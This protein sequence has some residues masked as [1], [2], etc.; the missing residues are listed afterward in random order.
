[1]DERGTAGWLDGLGASQYVDRFPR[2][3]IR[4]DVL[5]DLSEV[6]LQGPGIPAG[7]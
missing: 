6:D 5:P 4:C 2:N 7:S 3:E 1:M